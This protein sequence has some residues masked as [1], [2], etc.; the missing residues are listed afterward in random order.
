MSVTLAVVDGVAVLS[1]NR[2]ERHNAIDDDLHEELLT[3]WGAAVEDSEARVILL[4]G[5]GPSFCSGRDTAQ[6]GERSAGE[7][8]LSFVRRHQDSRIA[9]LSCPKP[10][11]AAVQGHALGGGLEL[12]LA[13]DIRIVASDVRMAF[14]EICYGLMTDTGGAPLATTLIGPA[15]TKWML[16][17]GRAVGAQQALEWGLAD[18]VV[19]PDDLDSHALALATEIA[20]KPPEALAVIKA[21]VDGMWQ[22]Q[23]HAGLRSELLGQVALFAGADYQARRAA[24]K[25]AS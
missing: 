25:G 15:R 6:L 16:M 17:T 9:Q 8:D 22:A 2:P 12:A 13:A 14:P 10:V 18:E 21:T 1:L 7:S 3:C 19:P 20:T 23:V 4:R 11:I 5:E 24:R